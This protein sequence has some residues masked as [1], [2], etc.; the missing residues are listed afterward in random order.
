M[1]IIS[2]K[3]K[4]KNTTMSITGDRNG[5]M[6]ITIGFFFLVVVVDNVG[7]LSKE[8]PFEIASSYEQLTPLVKIN[9]RVIHGHS[10]LTG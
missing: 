4:K 7:N 8:E 2:V 9:C 1:S 10:P 6:G 5:N 3:K